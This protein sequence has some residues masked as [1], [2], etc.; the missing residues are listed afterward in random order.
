[1]VSITRSAEDTAND[2]CKIVIK[3]IVIPTDLSDKRLQREIKKLLREIRILE[4][5]L[6]PQ[7]HNAICLEVQ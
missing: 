4:K 2:N 3:R 7:V 6:N 1:M 5:A